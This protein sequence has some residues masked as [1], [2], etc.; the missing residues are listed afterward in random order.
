VRHAMYVLAVLAR[1]DNACPIW[2][3]LNAYRQFSVLRLVHL[4]TKRSSQL[5]RAAWLYFTD[6]SCEIT[7]KFR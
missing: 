5:S 2:A 3:R 4:I 7:S 6:G 1:Y